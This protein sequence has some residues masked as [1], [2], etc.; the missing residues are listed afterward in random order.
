MNRNLALEFV[1]VTEMAAISSA[2][3]MGRGDEKAADQA[4]VDAMRTMLDS[5]ECNATV[6][7]GEGE[8]D[9]A[10]MLYIGEKVGSG[11][12]PELDIALD[13]LEGTTVCANGGWNSIAVMAIAEKGNFL[14]A[15]DTY[16]EKIAVGPEGKGLINIDDTP[17]ENLK[18]LAEAKKCRIQDLT[19]VIL[20]RPRH[21]ELI[22]QVR[23]AGAR[24]QLIGD[25]DVSAA[26]ACS[27]PDSGIDIL[28][29][30]G[31]A[32]EGVI[33]AAA[34]RCI[35]GDF[36]GRLKPRNDEEIE[37]AKTMG[38]DDINKI[39]NIDELAAGNVMF[40]ATGVTDGSFLNGVKFKSWGAVTESIVMRSQSGT[41]RRIVAEHR[42]DTKPR[43]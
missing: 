10:P 30:I 42:F 3:L 20:D 5:V 37:R 34:L 11:N 22:R 4:A 14:N 39:Y 29:G 36:Q 32:P 40:C 27:E 16:M 23:D 7:I 2:R 17:A 33:A 31:G 41:I 18:R 19:A 26:I 43:Y 15:P 13:P 25:G 24:I 9:E 12:G 38:I 6:V 28:F 8:R 1:R 21:E 35:G